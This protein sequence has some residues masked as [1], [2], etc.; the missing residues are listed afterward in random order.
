MSIDYTPG[1]GNYKDLKPF[2][3]WCQKVLPLVYDD[4][5]SYYELLCKVVDYLNK[6]MEDVETL[7]GDISSIYEA[8]EQLETYVNEY[9]DNLDVQEEI[10]NKLDEMAEDGSLTSIL[11]PIVQNAMI[12]VFVSS[13]SQMT[14][15]TKIYVLSP[16][17]YMYYYT[18]NGWMNSGVIYGVSSG[19]FKY[20]NEVTQNL[21]NYIDSGWYII[22]DTSLANDK[23]NEAEGTAGSLIII[24]PANNTVYSIQIYIDGNNHSWRRFVNIRDNTTTAWVRTIDSTNGLMYKGSITTSI[25]S[26]REQGWYRI[27]NTG[28]TVT[29]LPND[30]DGTLGQL[31]IIYPSVI[32]GYA[33]QKLI[34]SSGTNFTR[35]ISS[36][37]TT[38][39]I[40]TLN[41][42]NGL[43]YKG[44]IIS[45][46]DALTKQGW[47]I[48][49]NTGGTVTT[50]PDDFDSTLGL[51]EV[52]F[53]ATTPD[54]ALQRLISGNGTIFTRFVSSNNTTQWIKTLNDK[55]GLSYKGYIS[56]SIDT[57]T[58]CG[59]YTINN[60][61]GNV[62]TLP[63]DY[64]GVTG[65]LEVFTP[66][67]N[68]TYSL[69][70]L[71]SSNGTVYIRYTA[72][73]GSTVW[74]EFVMNT[75]LLNML[76]NINTLSYHGAITG[77]LS[78]YRTTGMWNGT[79]SYVPTDRP[80]TYSNYFALIV[81]ENQ[82]TTAFVGQIY[83]NGNSDMY[84][85]V[86]QKSNGTETYTWRRFSKRY[87][88]YVNALTDK[89]W[90]ACGD[91]F[92]QGDFTGTETPTIG[93]NGRYRNNK[94]TY[95]YWIGTRC[96]PI[97]NTSFAVNG[98][99]LA[100]RVTGT[101]G[102]EF[103]AH[104][105]E[106]PADADYITLYFG[107]NDSS[108]C[109]LGTINDTTKDTF[110]GAWYEVLTWIQTNRPNAKLG[111]IATNAGSLNYNL[112]TKAMCKKLGVPCLDMNSTDHML[113]IRNTSTDVAQTA[114][115]IADTKYRVSSS[116]YHP[117]ALCHRLESNFIE[118][119]L[120]SL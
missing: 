79:G 75:N 35:F 17:G 23:P 98:A 19:E 25:D 117:N 92:T 105:T 2:R 112:A 106:I 57:L 55:N 39:W 107:I 21:S 83:I 104:Y 11:I 38:Q 80:D 1:R 9:F 6:T 46:I 119:W 44:S 108:Y 72:S 93:G 18:D 53:P 94:P 97:V 99:T 32:E 88:D 86:I 31:E 68:D 24:A 118:E 27:N 5:L 12:P 78:E 56:E 4:S 91:S 87:G 89:K 120:L 115:D 82:P 67:T 100:K 28:G 3:F 84:Y 113:V 65:I 43:S 111:V 103:S 74:H 47:Y 77:E 34:S 73:T 13:T 101:A 20:R 62:T 33:L 71:T 30:F 8:Y 64:S 61:G 26:L 69:Q 52:V 59:W 54:Y 41:N 51:L 110:Y 114:K 109:T 81:L 58:E 14:D 37:N 85:R 66:G 40:K 76:Q 10:N 95:P 42:K 90:Y 45:S 50:L 29:T 96:D 102:Y 63:A 15:T 70:R 48:I 49:N 116:N 36:D 16:D 7:E 60:S 22:P